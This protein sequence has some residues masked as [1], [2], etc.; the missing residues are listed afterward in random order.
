[1]V[2]KASSAPEP[3]A[4]PE[5]SV[6]PAAPAAP[7]APAAERR[8]AAAVAARRRLRV[9]LTI[10]A[11]N[12]L[13]VALAA[14]AVVPW[15]F[16]AIPAVLLVAW[17]VACRLMVKKERAVRPVAARPRVAEPAPV[18]EGPATEEIAAVTPQEAPVAAPLPRDPALWDPV[19]VTLP[20]YV[21]KP[22]AARRTV[23][24]IDLDDT[25]VWTSGRSESDSQLAREAEAAERAARSRDDGDA[26]HAVGS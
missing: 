17:L 6:A 26:S 1:V 8:A 22:A 19:P 2:G 20:T 7:V 16:V 11:L 13:V 21:G 23:R 18:A 25:G 5:V 15:P 9:V 14:F 12:V 4:A 24:T 10:L 3:V